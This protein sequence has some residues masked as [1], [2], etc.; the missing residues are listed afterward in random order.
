MHKRTM[1]NPTTQNR[2][3]HNRIMH[4]RTMHK[5]MLAGV[6]AVGLGAPIAAHAQPAAVPSPRP[7]EDVFVI[8]PA[9]LLTIGAGIVVGAVLLDVILPTNVAFV[10]GGAVGGYLANVWY[11]GREVQLQMST[12]PRS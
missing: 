12:V 4:H 8:R 10:I 2:T 9:Q 11:G 7:S 1:Q 3:M 5:A 6:L